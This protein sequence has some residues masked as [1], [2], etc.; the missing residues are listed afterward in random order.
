MLLV[1]DDDGHNYLTRTVIARTAVTKN[2]HITCNGREAI[3]YVT[4]RGKFKENGDT[5]PKPEIILLDINMPVMDGWGFLE[6]YRKLNNAYKC[7]IMI[8][9]LTTSEN[10][11]EMERARSIREVSAFKSKPLTKEVLEEVIQRYFREH[12]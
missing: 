12:A 6:E 8:I 3:D 7:G 2:V 5:Y 9:I 11:D 10:P 4:S 1:D